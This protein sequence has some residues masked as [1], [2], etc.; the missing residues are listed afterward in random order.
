VPLTYIGV[1]LIGTLVTDGIWWDW[2]IALGA[3][4]WAGVC[5]FALSLLATARRTA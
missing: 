3:W 1:Y 5:G 4:I 2:N